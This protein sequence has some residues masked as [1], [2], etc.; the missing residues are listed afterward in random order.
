MSAATEAKELQHQKHKENKPL[1]AQPRR[2][3]ANRCEYL[4]VRVDRIDE[5]LELALEALN[6]KGVK[7]LVQ[8]W[9]DRQEPN[10]Q[11]NHPYNGGKQR[12]R[13]GPGYDPTNPVQS[14]IPDWWPL[15]VCRHKEPDHLWK[16][17]EEKA[18]FPF[19]PYLFRLNR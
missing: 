5:V 1:T 14:S 18:V 6:Q 10:K 4:E 19:S 11:S 9:I 16:E 2:E 8:A 3:P 15:D 13:K 12:K 7:K 17:G